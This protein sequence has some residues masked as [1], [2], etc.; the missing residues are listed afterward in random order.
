MIADLQE[1]DQLPSTRRYTSSVKYPTAFR[2][3]AY[4]RPTAE[5]LGSRRDIALEST[6]VER[7]ISSL[8]RLWATKDFRGRSTVA[9]RLT[10]LR[11]ACLDEEVDLSLDSVEQ[12]VRFVAKHRGMLTPDLAITAEGNVRASWTP[13]IDRHFAIE[14]LGGQR[15]KFVLFVPRQDVPVARMAGTE[16]GGLVVLRAEQMGVNWFYESPRRP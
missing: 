6:D 13:D 15:V 9:H 3:Q 4:N 16:A 10:A 14:F 2:R 1:P 5:G 11:S 7:F 8:E 12:F